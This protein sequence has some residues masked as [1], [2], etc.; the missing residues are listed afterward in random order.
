MA[1]EHCENGHIGPFMYEGESEYIGSPYN[2][3]RHEFVT[4][5]CQSCFVETQKL[6]VYEVA[7]VLNTLV[8]L[9]I[10]EKEK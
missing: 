10:S 4:L 3:E 5:T 9:P 6:S 1:K 8:K 2:Q 7:D